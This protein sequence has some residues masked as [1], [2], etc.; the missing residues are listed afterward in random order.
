MNEQCHQ[1]LQQA[2]NMDDVFAIVA[3]YYD[4]NSAKLT[5]VTRLT[6]ISGIKTAIKLTNAKEK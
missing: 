4:L 1:E 5:F 6:V 3:K 2:N